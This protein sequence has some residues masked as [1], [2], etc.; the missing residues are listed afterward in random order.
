[1]LETRARLAS[2]QR[3][4]QWGPARHLDMSIMQDLW[5]DIAAVE[6]L[7]VQYRLLLDEGG[8]GG[9]LSIIESFAPPGSGPPRHVHHEEDETFVIL[10]GTCRMW[11]EGEES[12]AGPGA[13]V[14]IGRGREHTFKV[15][16]DAP[17]RHLIILSPGGFEGFFAEMAAGSFRI[18]EDMDAVT[19]AAGR[20]HLSFTGPPLD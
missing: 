7:G 2:Q 15:T 6:W 12:L 5:A 9:A 11:L 8:S 17:S 16:D 18:P 4:V 1:M 10:S 13:T 3:P 20:H 14:F 19:E